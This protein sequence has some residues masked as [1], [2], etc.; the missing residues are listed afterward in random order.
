MQTGLSRVSACWLADHALTV[1][2]VGLLAVGQVGA[3]WLVPLGW[4]ALGLSALAWVAESNGYAIPRPGRAP[5]V[6]CGCGEVPLAFGVSRGGRHFLF[7]RQAARLSDPWPDEYSVYEMPWISKL[8]VASGLWYPPAGARRY[9]AA[10]PTEDLRF[11]HHQ[12]S[13]VDSASLGRALDR[14]VPRRA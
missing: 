12:R 14:V 11:E 4:M 6:G 2:G 1:A 10:V 7:A 3:G 13:Y 9:N 5:I 8:Q